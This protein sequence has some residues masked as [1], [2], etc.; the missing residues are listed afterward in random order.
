MTCLRTAAHE[1]TELLTVLYF[2]FRVRTPLPKMIGR[3]L[4]KY[5]QVKFSVET[6][7]ISELERRLLDEKLDLG[8]G[9]SENNRQTLKTR[10]LFLE[11][12]VAVANAKCGLKSARSI[13]LEEIAAFPLVL[14]RD[15]EQSCRNRGIRLSQNGYSSM[16]WTYAAECR[17]TQDVDALSRII[18]VRSVVHMPVIRTIR[19]QIL[20]PRPLP[21][22]PTRDQAS[23]D[24]PVVVVV[25]S[26]VSDQV[27]QL[28]GWI[29]G[30]RV[31]S[32]AC[33][34]KHR[35]RYFRCRP[36]LLGKR[37]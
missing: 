30:P 6:I 31:A 7:D 24:F 1:E 17:S 23:G 16:N 36:Y 9:F 8:V 29:V 11:N 32:R 34:P 33:L 35:S 18:G 22:L 37:A 26:G 14:V 28:Q 4:R 19:P 12:L 21:K 15:F 3:F 20:N 10:E 27:P 25:D 2:P 5:L 13:S